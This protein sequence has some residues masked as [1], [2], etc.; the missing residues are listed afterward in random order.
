[1]Y[2]VDLFDLW[3]LK[4]LEN[5]HRSSDETPA[6]A[7]ARFIGVSLRTIQHWRRQKR[8]PK[9]GLNL[10]I[11]AATG[12]P[13]GGPAKAATAWLGWRFLHL[14]LTDLDKP[15]PR[16]GKRGVKYWDWCLVSPTGVTWSP[17]Q[18]DMLGFQMGRLRDLEKEL[19]RLQGPAQFLLPLS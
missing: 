2:D 4:A 10:L 5:C 9:W 15:G 7:L 11:Y 8:A 6:A 16:G 18:L 3:M 14:E 13:A 19:K 17:A 1:M 12:V